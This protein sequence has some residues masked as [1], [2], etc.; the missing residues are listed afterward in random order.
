MTATLD[1]AQHMIARV[2]ALM[3][4][5]ATAQRFILVGGTT[6]L[7]YFLLTFIMVEGL[8]LEVVSSSTAAYILS[9]CYNYLLHYYWTFSTKA[10]H[11]FVVAKYVLTCAGGVLINAL[12]MH[13]GVSLLSVHYVVVQVFAQVLMI[14]WSI[15]ISAL[16]VFK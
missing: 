6:S 8:G 13:F 3:T 16:W 7:L 5:Y 15:T 1:K 12:V 9:V 11:G 14:C 4:K 10:S 2:R